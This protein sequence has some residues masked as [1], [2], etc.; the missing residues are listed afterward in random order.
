MI[1]TII[2]GV[3]LGISIRGFQIFAIAYLA[4]QITT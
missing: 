1:T 4:N 2:A 3:Y